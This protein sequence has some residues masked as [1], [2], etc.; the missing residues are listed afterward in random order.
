MTVPFSDFNQ[1]LLLNF[2]NQVIMPLFFSGAL[3][4]FVLCRQII[5]FSL[6]CWVYQKCLTFYFFWLSRSSKFWY[7]ELVLVLMRC[8]KRHIM[9][10]IG[11]SRHL[12]LL[13]SGFQRIWS[14]WNFWIKINLG[15]A[16]IIR[17]GYDTRTEASVNFLNKSI[18]DLKRTSSF[19]KF[20]WLFHIFLLLM[21]DKFDSFK[22]INNICQINCKN[23]KYLIQLK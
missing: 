1:L 2:V 17:V 21:H 6:N 3:H 19:C 10:N 11:C 9:R 22:R 5:V 14:V 4:I 20:I 8:S 13:I 23:R 16:I 12:K 7:F 18:F 15:V